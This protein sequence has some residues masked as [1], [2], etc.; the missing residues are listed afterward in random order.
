M[1]AQVRLDDPH[2]QHF[3]AMTYNT[4]GEPAIALDLLRKA[5]AGALP[6]SELSA[7]IDLDMLHGS[8]QFADLLR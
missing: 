8:P 1:L 6:A 7:W 4:L 5:R 2:L 3:A